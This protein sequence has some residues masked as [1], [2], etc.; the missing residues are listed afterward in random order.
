LVLLTPCSAIVATIGGSLPLGKRTHVNP[1]EARTTALATAAIAIGLAVA[2]L[3][4]KFAQVVPAGGADAVWIVLTS[5]WFI[6]ATLSSKDVVANAAAAAAAKESAA[7]WLGVSTLAN[8]ER[9]FIGTL[10][11]VAT[12]SCPISGVMSTMLSQRGQA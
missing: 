1:P 2:K 7:C 3:W 6:D 9:G 5:V 10:F 4:S 12:P 8:W 11:E